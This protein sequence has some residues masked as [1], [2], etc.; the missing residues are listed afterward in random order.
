MHSRIAPKKKT[1]FFTFFSSEV[2]V[3]PEHRREEK[4][5][6]PSPMTPLELYPLNP[7]VDRIIAKQKE[8]EMSVQCKMKCVIM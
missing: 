3:A 8:E 5:M 1:N 4:S 7:L 6:T 2:K